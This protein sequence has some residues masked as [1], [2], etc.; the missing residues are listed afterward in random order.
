MLGISIP[1]K[2]SEI[3]QKFQ[4]ISKIENVMLINTDIGFKLIFLVYQTFLCNMIQCNT[5]QHTTNLNNNSAIQKH[6]ILYI[7]HCIKF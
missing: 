3:Y 7:I 6:V 5:I 2:N 4:Y 1:G